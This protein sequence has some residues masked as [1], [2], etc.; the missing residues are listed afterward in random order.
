[1]TKFPEDPGEAFSISGLG[2]PCRAVGDAEFW[3]GGDL[4]LWVLVEVMGS[5]PPI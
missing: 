2:A 4:E 1:M 3:K 5:I